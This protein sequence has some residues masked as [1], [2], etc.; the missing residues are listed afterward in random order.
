MLQ[1][2]Q[3]HKQYF[4]LLRTL[5]RN[6]IVQHR[7]LTQ[8]FLKS[9]IQQQLCENFSDGYMTISS[10]GHIMYLNKAGAQILNKR[11]DQLMG[12]ALGESFNSTIDLLAT[13][14]ENK[15]IAEEEGYFQIENKKIRVIV[16]AIPLLGENS[17]PLGV[18]ITFNA[19]QNIRKKLSNLVGSS[20]RF[21]FDQILHQSEKMSHLITLAKRSANNESSILIEG[22][23]GTGKEMIAQA[24][25]NY[26]KRRD[27]P[28]VTIDCS[29]IPRELIESELFGYVEGAFTGAQKGGRIGKF[30]LANGGTIFLDEI[31]EMPLEMQVRLLRVI[32]NRKITRVGSNEEIP[33]DV[34]IISATNRDLEQEV[35]SNNFRLDLFYRLNVIQLE[36]PA[37]R[38]RVGR[39]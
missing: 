25:H 31:G 1:G 9:E 2:K 7:N 22:E 17:Y 4:E 30:E 18:L 6:S 12:T 28:F 21:T 3:A 23:S 16:T 14:Q 35:A 20:A 33:I 15:T 32:Q 13:I 38:E 34:R 39:T 19:L 26:S 24:I 8:D 11:A 5:L 27:E 10:D 29:S 36:V 37:V